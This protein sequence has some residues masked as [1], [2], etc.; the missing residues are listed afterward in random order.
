MDR[1][2]DSP[3]TSAPSGGRGLIRSSSRVA[4][5]ARPCL[6]M[7]SGQGLQLLG[8]RAKVR[9]TCIAVHS[10]RPPAVGSARRRNTAVG[11]RSRNPP[12]EVTPTWRSFIENGSQN[13]LLALLLA[14]SDHPSPLAGRFGEHHAPIAA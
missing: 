10:F 9:A 3:R 5:C 6:A 4:N 2:I 8:K 1:E 11:Q 7:A 14:L 12:N 13:Q